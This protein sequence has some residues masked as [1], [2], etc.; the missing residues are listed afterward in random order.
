MTGGG[1]GALSGGAASRRLASLGSSLRGLLKRLIARLERR[2]GADDPLNWERHVSF[3]R[4]RWDQ[5]HDERRLGAISFLGA[6]GAEWDERE[7]Q[8][9][10]ERFV[11]RMVSR[12]REYGAP[13]DLGSRSVLEIGCGV[14]RFLG[15]LSRSFGS[16]VGVD[17]SDKMLASA[18]ARLSS[19]ANLRIER[20][21]GKDL[22]GFADGSFD[23]CVCAGV[24]QHVTLRHIILNYVREG[25]RVIRPGGMFLF[26]FQGNKRGAAGPDVVR[27]A[28]LRA[29]DLDEALE[30]QPFRIRELSSDPLDRGR[31]VV[32]VIEKLAPGVPVPPQ[33]RLFAL[34]RL[35]DKPWLTGVYDGLRTPVLE[36][37][38]RDAEDREPLTFF[39]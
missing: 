1:G 35:S 31:S 3:M 29:R 9:V 33:E 15:P 19:V 39:D 6:Q 22:E 14:G 18:R 12:F 36:Q 8:L 10:G 34:R 5:L 37:R 2:T 20:N 4:R 30:G 13:S 28:Q 11:A 27:G 25:L 38:A 21:N 32:V 24:F 26:Q 7:F 17:V 16:V 23:F